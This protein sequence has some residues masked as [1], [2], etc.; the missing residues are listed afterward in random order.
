MHYVCNES[1]F[2]SSLSKQ[3]TRQGVQ[4]SHVGVVTEDAVDALLLIGEDVVQLPLQ[5]RRLPRWP[6]GWGGGRRGGWTAGR[7]PFRGTRGRPV[8]RGVWCEWG[9]GPRSRVKGLDVNGLLLGR[10]P[11]VRGPQ[12]RGGGLSPPEGKKNRRSEEQATAAKS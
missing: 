7:V 1:L 6:L 3:Q 12:R 10:G 8:H 11:E 9:G 4:V 5:L 2:F